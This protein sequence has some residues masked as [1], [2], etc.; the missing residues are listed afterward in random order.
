MSID[1]A[2]CLHCDRCYGICPKKAILKRG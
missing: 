1:Q 2:H